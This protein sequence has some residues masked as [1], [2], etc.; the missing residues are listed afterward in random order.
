MRVAIMQP[1]WLPWIGYFDLIEQVDLFVFLDTVQFCRRSW[2]CRN[3]IKTDAG[4]RWLSMPT[5]A[6]RLSATTLR[7]ARVCPGAQVRKW[8]MSL[9]LA[10]ADAAA[11]ETEL[12]WILDRLDGIE[13]GAA[14]ADV[15]IG[16]IEVIA[17]RL[18]IGTP[19]VR[20]SALPDAD[21]RVGRLVSLC[22]HLGAT[23][24]VSPPGAVGY[25]RQ[26]HR[27]FGDAGLGLVF[28]RYDHPIYRQCHLPFLS[29]ASVLDLLL[30]HG[31]DAADILRTGRRNPIPAADLFDRHAPGNNDWQDDIQAA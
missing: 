30:N 12:P 23:T 13:D 4:L 15:N 16:F 29:H 3:R 22:R 31:D 2:H 28:H 14:L 19:V 5:R 9:A 7:E 6:S 18:G 17:R 10:Y 8:R 11:R 20:A 21:G 25:L 27:A 26:D 24:Y 1:T